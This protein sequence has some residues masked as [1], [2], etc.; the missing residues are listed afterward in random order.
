MEFKDKFI[1]F[2]DILGFSK[3]VKAA[4]VGTG[5]SLDELL[6]MLEVLGKAEDCMR[7]K[8]QGAIVC[9]ESPYIQRDLDFRL[10]QISDSVVV[11]CEISPAGVINLLNHCWGAV[12]QLLTKGIMCRGY[13]TQGSVYHSDK[14]IIGTGY[15]EAYR[16]EPSVTAFKREADERRTP[17]VEV[18]QVI[19]DFIIEHGDMCV[20]NRFSRYVKTDGNVTALFPFKMLSHSFTVAGF[21]HTFDPEK[22][23][24]ANENLRR[25]IQKVKHLVTELVDVSNPNAVSKANHYISALDV[26]LKECD[27]TDQVIDM[28]NSPS[29]KDRS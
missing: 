8:K 28:L 29:H 5:M 14:Q 6:K 24:L 19:C 25:M 1:A 3:L 15:Q 23:K 26:Q 20:K 9:P 7:I 21:G 10:T 18:D 12:M 11:S 27:K 17:F 13:I 16:R 22:E 2:V 4:E